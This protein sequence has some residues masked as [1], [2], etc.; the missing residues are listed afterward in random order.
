MVVQLPTGMVDM[1]LV[2]L[3]AAGLRCALEVEDTV[4][5]RDDRW[6]RDD[7]KE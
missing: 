1:P 3:L 6:R 2:R 7:R 5:C 4:R